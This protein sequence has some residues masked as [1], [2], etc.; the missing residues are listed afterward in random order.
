MRPNP[1][2][3]ELP[4]ASS[5]GSGVSFLNG[6]PLP[7]EAWLSTPAPDVP[8]VMGCGD[9]GGQCLIRRGLV[10][11]PIVKHPT[12][13]LSFTGIGG[14]SAPALGYV[15]MPIFF[16]DR[17]ALA[18]KPS[19]TIVKVWIE[20]QVVECLDCNFLIGRDATR[21]YSIDFVESGGYIMVGGV[22]IPIAY[23]PP[24]VSL[25]PCSPI[26]V[27]PSQ[28]TVI[29]PHSEA[30][31][32]VT[33]PAGLPAD[34][35]LI[36]HPSCFVDL[37]RELHGRIPWTLL[38]ASCPSVFFSNLCSYPIRLSKGQPVGHVEIVSANTMMS[39]LCMPP[40]AVSTP[41][42]PDTC[43]VDPFGPSVGDE[44]PADDKATETLTLTDP[45]Y[46]APLSLQVNGLLSPHMKGELRPLLLQFTSVFSFG[47]RRLGN[48]RLPPMTI[49]VSG[50]LPSRMP[51]YRESP[52]QSRLIRESMATLKELDIIEEGTGPMA[53]PVVMILQKGKWR[54][55]VDFRA[56]NAITPL[57]RYPIPRPDT[58]FTAL[59]GA[60]FFSTMD[61]NKW[62]H[63]FEIDERHRHLTVFVTQQEGQ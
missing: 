26:A 39:L 48:V 46:P 49:E 17:E 35:A 19:G 33:M 56:V 51:A 63:Q 43:S 45:H 27:T 18:G 61:A 37:P 8:T 42:D 1:R 5:L 23:G 34:K 62:Y 4:R 58:V 21:A 44:F 22:Q 59:S 38:Y 12:L 24:K 6:N 13:S 28:D 14:S 30:L 32:N 7:I 31:I 40:S 3:V 2:V 16:P 54:F 52:R 11:G 41:A 36:L 57:D 20:F 25:A 10:V 55:C 29:L 53:A 15:V 47:G 9:S 60:E 50:P